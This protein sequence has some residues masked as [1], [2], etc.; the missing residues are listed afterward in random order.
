[1]PVLKRTRP[2]NT[3]L[4]DFYVFDVETGIRD[5]EGP[6][7]QWHLNARPESFIFGVIYGRN[8]CKVIHNL[9]EFHETLLEPR[10]KKRKVFAHNATYD[11]GTLFG[12]IFHL[13]PSAIFAGSRF[14]SCTNGNCVFADSLNIYRTS[15]KKLG[16]MMGKAKPDLGN[17][18]MYSPNGVTA[19][20]INRCIVDCEIVWE[21]LLM[22]FED[23]GN[24]KI[25]QASLSL[26]YY[27]AHH[28]PHN[29][30][31]TE[32]TK[33]FWDSYYGGRCEAFK[34]GNTHANVIDVNSMYPDRMKNEKFPNPKFLK[35]EK[36]PNKINQK[37]YI[38]NFIQ[39]ILPN[40]EG[41]IYGDV[42][43]APNWFGLLPVKSNGKLLF[44]CGHISGCWN[45][46][47]FRYA[48][49]TG[50]VELV[51]IRGVVYGP[52]MLS[53]FES[54]VT[55]LYAKRFSTKNPLEIYRIKI[56]MNSLYG[57]FAQRIN[58]ETIYIENIDRQIKVIQDYQAKGLFIKLSLFNQDRL[59][60]FL[61]VKSVRKIDRSFSIPSFA[62]Y[63]TSG[64]RVQLAKKLFE[65]EKNRP[66]YCDTDSIFYEID[67]SRIETGPGL[68]QWKKENKTVTQ[69]RGLKNYRYIDHDKS[70]KEI[71][72]I[73]GVPEKSRMFA[74]MSFEYEN[75]LNTKE[76]LRRNLPA[77]VLTK[78]TKIITGKYD[79][80]KVNADGTTEPITK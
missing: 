61:T 41:L 38:N 69:I 24:I 51:N 49:S 21:S 55:T 54:Y 16:E 3:I 62:S 71:D 68:G 29:I 4:T 74:P 13:D 78:R 10:F 5:K 27:L 77:G 7:I 47:E 57:K 34:L 63:I 14:I 44:P 37:F 58:E 26:S 19:A 22:I 2:R 60:A 32:E 31:H 9:K 73:K 76:A 79:K 70:P 52:P 65:L 39:N 72:R 59:D 28:I 25:T 6:G 48:Q 23:V 66:V 42:V 36:G 11:L 67:D 75:L 17:E 46:N 1:M 8:Y 15:V 12:N 43:H 30:E 18:S 80:R 45:F 53:P 40:Y 35:Y 50:L 64:A 20:E 33:Y 56:F